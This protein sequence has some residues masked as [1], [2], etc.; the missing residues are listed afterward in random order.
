MTTLPFPA[1]PTL[2]FTGK[3]G[4]GKTSLA[5]ATAVAL[6]DG[7][8]R[9]LLVSTD[10]ASNLDEVLGVELS[11]RPT[12]VHGVP[13]LAALNIDPDAAAREYRERVVGPYR[14]LLPAATVRRMEEQ[15]SGGCTLEI[16][17]FDQFTSLLGAASTSAEYDHLIFDTAPTGHTLRLLKLPGAWTAFLDTNTTGTSCLGPLSGL[18]A[19]RTSYAASLAALANA[20]RTTV[21]LVTRPDAASLAE[22]ARSGEELAALGIANQRLIVNGIFHATDGNDP[23]ALAM[24]RRGRAA[25][26]AMPPVL[27]L[28]PRIDVR[29]RARAPLGIDGLRRFFDP[30]GGDTDVDPP[31]DETAAFPP[32]AGLIDAIERDGPAVI[33][34]MGKGGVGKTTIA[35]A[36][37][38][39]LARR[40]HEVLLS[41]TDP[42]AH[43]GAAIGA[44]IANLRVARIDPIAETAA[45]HDEV[46]AGA[47]PTL[48]A[49]GLDLLEEDLRSPCTEEV[50]VFRAFART[51]A[52]RRHR[53]VVL[54][55]APTG[56]TLLLLDAAQAYHRDV[57][58]AQGA[59]PD[60]V[61]RLLPTLRDRSAAKVLVVTLPEAT[62]VHEAARLQDDLRRAGIEPFAWVVNQTLIGREVLD[63][64]L[65]ARR[66]LEARYA[67]EACELAAGRVAY[68]GWM[69]DPPVG[70]ERLHR[71]VE[72]EARDVRA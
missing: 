43:V 23:F 16:A 71:L 46:I 4:V 25:L 17:A 53:F 3:G 48:D 49:R 24:A 26:D 56:H 1:T 60:A 62:P 5:C 45:Y 6:A 51:V 31:L 54:D 42:A 10:P 59:V 19:Q 39:E 66:A 37:A 58:R 57:A 21:F 29:L 65:R 35:A 27:T 63:P 28:L 12:A 52:D 34:V 69:A 64:V 47:R 36:I 41:T 33:L 61:R 40:G 38:T 7:G 2:F 68:V 22:A 9:V 70:P 32:L 14:A 20:A 67:R 8:R 13:N 44:G 15:L 55:T 11:T 72:G 30:G 50:A 18:Q